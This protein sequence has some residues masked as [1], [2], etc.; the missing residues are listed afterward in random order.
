MCG[1]VIPYLYAHEA[2][3]RHD[4]LKRVSSEIYFLFRINHLLIFRKLS[5]ICYSIVINN[6]IMNYEKY[7]CFIFMLNK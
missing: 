5:G 3:A 4:P 2:S 7:I 6:Q 1:G